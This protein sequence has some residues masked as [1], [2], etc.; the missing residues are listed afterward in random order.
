MEIKKTINAEARNGILYLEQ[1]GELS[2]DNINNIKKYLGTL[3]FS[4]SNIKISF[5]TDNKKVK[6]GEEVSLT[7]EAVATNSELGMSQAAG[8]FKDKYTFKT[9]LHSISKAED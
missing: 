8:L 7:I 2:A 9:T 4:L 5:N 3:G 6:Y 1:N